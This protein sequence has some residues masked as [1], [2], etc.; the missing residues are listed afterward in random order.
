MTE[1][2]TNG[3]G[4]YSVPVPNDK[5]ALAARECELQLAALRGK[6]FELR[7]TTSKKAPVRI[8]HNAIDIL[9]HILEQLG[10][11]NTLSLF[12]SNA[13]LTTQQAVDLLWVSRPF[14]VKLLESGDIPFHKVGSHRRV[15]YEDVFRYKADIDTKRRKVLTELTREAQELGLGY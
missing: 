5:E 8:P 13:Q 2:Q 9:C 14:I 10:Q 3:L 4:A 15:I 7:S 11:G 6:S 1:H 12:Q